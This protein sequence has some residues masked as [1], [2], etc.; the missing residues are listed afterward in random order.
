MGE[1]EGWLDNDEVCIFGYVVYTSRVLLFVI[2][3]KHSCDLVNVCEQPSTS[4]FTGRVW[5]A[6]CLRWFL[7]AVISQ[8]LLDST[9]TRCDDHSVHPREVK[10]FISTFQHQEHV[11]SATKHWTTLPQTLNV[12]D[13]KA[14]SLCQISSRGAYYAGRAL[15]SPLMTLYVERTS[16]FNTHHYTTLNTTLPPKATKPHFSSPTTTHSLNCCHAEEQG[17]GASS[18][19]PR[20]AHHH[21]LNGRAHKETTLTPRCRVVRT[22]EGERTR[23][24][25]R[26]ASS[27]SRR[28]VKVRSRNHPPITPRAHR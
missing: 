2:Q 10:S 26:S 16:D 28:R 11:Q 5:P 22:G 6:V 7:S 20:H 21:L 1:F 3:M 13:P 23:T 19:V 15:L 4:I 17:K 27:P 14:M 18:K 25:T 12:E 24:T 8:A 9:R